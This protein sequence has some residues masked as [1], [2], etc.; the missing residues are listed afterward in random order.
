MRRA[1]RCLGLGL[2]LLFACRAP[3]AQGD[4]YRVR[5]QVLEQSGSGADL[6]VVVAHEAIANFKGRD[7][8][9]ATMPAMSMAFGVADRLD[10][11]RFRPG[12]KWRLEVEVH[13]Q[14]EPT[15]LISAAEPLPAEAPL[16]LDLGH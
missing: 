2:G 7:G 1:L 4:V 5:G 6:R 13:W 10:S 11:A 9:L 16:Q 15:L 8:Q 12:S 3:G 14:H